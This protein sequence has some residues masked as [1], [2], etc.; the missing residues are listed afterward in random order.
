MSDP[1]ASSVIALRNVSKVY[2]EAEGAPARTILKDLSL[3]LAGGE[4]LAVVGPSGCGKSTLLN[5][6]GL[7]DEPSAGEVELLGQSVGRLAEPARA[8]LRAKHI[9][10]VFQLHHLLPQLTVLEN[11]LLPTLALPKSQRPAEAEARSRAESLLERVGLAD[12]RHRRPAT[13]SGGERQRT[14]IVRALINGPQLLLADEPTG[15]LDNA[16]AHD[17]MRL[18]DELRASTGVALVVVTHAPDLV[19]HFSRKI[20]L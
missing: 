6:M 16:R 7:L 20:S 5:I 3:T 11:V 15:A 14:A 1:A 12:L 10:F 13:L 17:L 9:G 4:A 19:A 8:D 18:L 2:P